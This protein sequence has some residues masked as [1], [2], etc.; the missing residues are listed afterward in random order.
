MPQTVD[1][2]HLQQETANL[3]DRFTVH[4]ALVDRELFVFAAFPSGGG[5]R[6]GIA[7]VGARPHSVIRLLVHTATRHRTVA[8]L[9][10]TFRSYSCMPV[11]APLRCS[12]GSHTT[13]QLS[14]GFMLTMSRR[15]NCAISRLGRVG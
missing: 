10:S 11:T 8:K 9:P 6:P 1:A 3:A 12:S 5:L 4:Q 7:D 15:M 14:G 2:E 13:F